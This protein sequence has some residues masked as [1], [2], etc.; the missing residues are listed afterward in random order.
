M[1]R[2]E[3]KNHSSHFMTGVAV[4][5]AITALFTTKTGRRLLQELTSQGADLVEG[6]VDLEKIVD[7]VKS[8]RD[9]DEGEKASTRPKKKRV[10]KG[11]KK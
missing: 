2:K 5:A 11:V 6:K 9:E 7:R 3:D 4:G 8:A 1:S 10:F